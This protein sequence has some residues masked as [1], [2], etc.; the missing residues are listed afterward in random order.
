MKKRT[1]GKPSPMYKNPYSGSMISAPPSKKELQT[2]KQPLL[3]DAH[4]ATKTLHDLLIA[5]KNMS[6]FTSTDSA[7][8]WTERRRALFLEFSGHLFGLEKELL[9]IKT[10]LLTI[11]KR[12]R[13][14]ECASCQQ[15]LEPEDLRYTTCLR[16]GREAK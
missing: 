11:N 16:C 6:L 3:F 15:E 4:A 12:E 8:H 10:E 13:T 14:I 5:D 2:P 1:L 7:V 9:T